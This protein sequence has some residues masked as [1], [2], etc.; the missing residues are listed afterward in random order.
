VLLVGV[1]LQ[2]ARRNRDFL[3]GEQAPLAAKA[4]IR[5]T[6]LDF[7]GIDSVEELLVT[8]I[9]PRQVWVVCRVGIDDALRGDQVEAIVH[10][11]DRS[12]RDQSAYVHRVDI[13]P[14]GTG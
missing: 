7:P 2:L 6:I 4:R 9:G 12:L 8:F 14:I 5:A 3:L 13:V 10:D 11:L 1:G